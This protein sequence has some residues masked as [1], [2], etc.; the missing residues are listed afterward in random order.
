MTLSEREWLSPYTRGY[1]TTAQE[2][3][4]DHLVVPVHTGYSHWRG[5]KSH[6]EPRAAQ[7]P[8]IPYPMLLRNPDRG[9]K[10]EL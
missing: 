4:Q 3:Q 2:I 7:T 5:K 6:A 9:Y 10:R 8:E 1:S